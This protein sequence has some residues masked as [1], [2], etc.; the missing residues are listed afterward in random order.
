MPPPGVELR[1]AS[2]NCRTST[3]QAQLTLGLF[4]FGR[5]NVGVSKPEF[6]EVQRKLDEALAKLK[7]TQDPNLRREL[8]KEMRLLLI[9]A[10]RLAY[11]L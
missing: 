2:K 8:L 6:A 9:E 10:E 1:S 7:A 5:Y 11:S 4:C 3:L